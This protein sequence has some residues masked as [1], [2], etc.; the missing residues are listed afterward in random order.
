[1]TSHISKAVAVATAFFCFPTVGA[2]S[3]DDNQED[4]NSSWYHDAAAVPFAFSTD[5]MGLSIG[6]AGVVKGRVNHRLHCLVLGL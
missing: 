1:M 2:A 5:S 6:L 4:T 3:G